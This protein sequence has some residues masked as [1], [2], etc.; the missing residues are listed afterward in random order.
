[1]S[2]IHT[3]DAGGA[4]PAYY[5]TPDGGDDGWGTIWREALGVNTLEREFICECCDNDAPWIIAAL[6]EY[7]NKRYKEL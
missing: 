4:A 7:G 5:F 6:T 2:A 3:T 1:M